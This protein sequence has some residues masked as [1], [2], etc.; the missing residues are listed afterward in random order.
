MSKDNDDKNM[1]KLVFQTLFPFLQ[2]LAADEKFPVTLETLLRPSNH[3]F[4]NLINEIYIK[5]PSSI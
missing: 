3:N 4:L 2:K 5:G 1:N